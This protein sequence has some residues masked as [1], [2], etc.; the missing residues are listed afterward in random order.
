[1]GHPMSYL[2]EGPHVASRAENRSDPLSQVT[3][4]SSLGVPSRGSIC[5]YTNPRFRAT[6]QSTCKDKWSAKCDE[7]WKSVIGVSDRVIVVGATKEY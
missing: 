4:L 1:M 2:G 6:A 7:H 3:R 5:A